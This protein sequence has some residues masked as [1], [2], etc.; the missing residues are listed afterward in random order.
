MVL[1]RLACYE[2]QLLQSVHLWHLQRKCNT[3]SIIYLTHVF[4]RFQPHFTVFLVC[5][6]RP[7]AQHAVVLQFVLGSCSPILNKALEIVLFG[8]PTSVALKKT[9]FLL[10][11]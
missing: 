4:G 9:H 2:Q 10:D 6:K 7:R 1:L 5:N 8:S 3:E 11:I